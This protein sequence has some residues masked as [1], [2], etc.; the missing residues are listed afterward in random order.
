M[1]LGFQKD[2]DPRLRGKKPPSWRA[3]ET[4]KV[5]VPGRKDIRRTVGCPVPLCP[6]KTAFTVGHWCPAHSWLK[7]ELV[8]ATPLEKKKNEFISSCLLQ[9]SHVSFVFTSSLYPETRQQ[10]FSWTLQLLQQLVISGLCFKSISVMFYID[11]WKWLLIVQVQCVWFSLTK[12]ERGK[13]GTGAARVIQQKLDLRD[14]RNTAE[15]AKD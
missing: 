14:T 9:C 2:C 6:Q 12:K 3:A 4:S 11:T 10:M 7:P 5:S 15:M 1:S 13:T 8:P